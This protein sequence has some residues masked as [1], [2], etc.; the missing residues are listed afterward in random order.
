MYGEN[1]ARDG[2]VCGEGRCTIS[3]RLPKAVN[4]Y[5]GRKVA[6]PA[7]GTTKAGRSQNHA[8][9]Q[10]FF[11]S[12]QSLF[13]A[14]LF[15]AVIISRDE[16]LLLLNIL[17]LRPLSEE[18]SWSACHSHLT[19][20]RGPGFA[21]HP[22]TT[23]SHHRVTKGKTGR[24]ETGEWEM[25]RAGKYHAENLFSVASSKKNPACRGPKPFPVECNDFDSCSA[26]IR[27]ATKRKTTAKSSLWKW[28]R[29]C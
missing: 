28:S 17:K 20:G 10:L 8:N 5:Q 14:G 23:D 12:L 1:G 4:N 24:K 13:P 21:Y 3:P 2:G 11:F 26:L 19:A 25:Q 6:E 27:Q 29:H 16:K 18:Q 7:L 15:P 22:S 9:K